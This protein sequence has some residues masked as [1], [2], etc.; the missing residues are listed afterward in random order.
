MAGLMSAI[1]P[2]PTAALL[3]RAGVHHVECLLPDVTGNPNQRLGVALSA[4]AGS[5]VAG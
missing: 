2:P 3:E 5:A 1:L 4:A